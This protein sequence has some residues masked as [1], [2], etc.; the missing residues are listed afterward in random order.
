MK[1]LFDSFIK[2][3]R[4]PT[5]EAVIQEAKDTYH[6]N[7]EAM[8]LQF[9]SSHPASAL[10]ALL[11]GEYSTVA[12]AT[13]CYEYAIN[14]RLPLANTLDEAESLSHDW[15][16]LASLV[17]AARYGIEFFSPDVNDIGIGVPILLEQLIFHAILRAQ[18][19]LDTLPELDED[20]LPS[21]LHGQKTGYLNLKEIA[22]LAQMHEKSVRNAT[23]PTAPDRLH[24]RKEGT[25]TVV[26]S[27]EALRWLK[28]RRNFKPSILR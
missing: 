26:D 5:L 17:L 14:G 24:T 16:S 1:H 18:L 19:D 27:H 23:Q 15:K 21:P 3:E 8:V 4:T 12:T 2:P 9:Y 11:G 22:V 13:A 20:M 6:G 10:D 28:G 25:R 7:L